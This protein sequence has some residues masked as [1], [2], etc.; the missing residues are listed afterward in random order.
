[1]SD[2]AMIVNLAN[3]KSAPTEIFWLMMRF[4]TYFVSIYFEKSYSFSAL[5]LKHDEIVSEFGTHGFTNG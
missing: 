1:M 4:D 5:K 2:Y 3:I